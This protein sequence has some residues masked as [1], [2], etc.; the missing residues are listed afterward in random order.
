MSGCFLQKLMVLNIYYGS[1]AR[2]KSN[3]IYG[4]PVYNKY[5]ENSYLNVCPQPKRVHTPKMCSNHNK[6]IAD[7]CKN[8]LI[9]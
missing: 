7:K 2:Q 6:S 8:R 3:H 9:V 5:S 4:K 1:I